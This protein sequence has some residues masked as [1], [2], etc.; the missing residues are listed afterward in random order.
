MNATKTHKAPAIDTSE[1][2][3]NPHLPDLSIVVP[4]HNEEGNIEQTINAIMSEVVRLNISTEI[5][6]VDDGSA[7]ATFK[8]ASNMG[9]HF[10]VSVLR[11]SR[12]FGKEHA[13]SAGLSASTGNIV[14]IIDADLQ[15]PISYLEEMLGELKNGYEMVYAVRGNRDDESVPKRL[16][17]SAFYKLLSMGSDVVI[18]Q[19]ARDFRVMN[20]NVVDALC[21]LPERNRFM[22]GLY[23]WIGFK[24]KAVP[25]EMKQRTSGRSSFG[26]SALFKLALTGITSFTNFPLRVWTGVGSVLAILSI[27]YGLWIF[28]KTIIWGVD[29]P[30]FATITVA[31]FFLGGIQL[32]SIGVIGEYLA[33]VFTEV[34]GRPGFIVAEISRPENQ[35][36]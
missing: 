25:I 17:T 33:R 27:L 9:Q 30:G 15:E 8:T 11:L 35:D 28:A 6:V 29:T 31:I 24:T 14:A 18:P 12:N 4:A 13:I 1:L 23:G 21:A 19:D 22:K 3:V 16:F 10:P 32:I 2:T 36:D 26:F 5:I 7:D 34:K 20:R